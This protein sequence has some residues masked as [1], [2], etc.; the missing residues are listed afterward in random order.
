MEGYVIGAD[1]PIAP[2]CLPGYPSSGGAASV[3]NG[4]ADFALVSDTGD[5]VRVPASYCR[6]LA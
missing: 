2:V 4:D 5:A 6:L 3:A 1:N